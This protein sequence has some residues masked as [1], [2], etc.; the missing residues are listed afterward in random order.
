MKI[1]LIYLSLLGILFLPYACNQIPESKTNQVT[2]ATANQ[3]EKISNFFDKDNT[4]KNP[5][6]IV[7]LID[8]S[9]SMSGARVE[10]VNVDDLKPI[11]EILKSHGGEIA[12]GQICEDSNKPLKRLQIPDIKALKSTDLNNTPKPQRD[13]TGSPF[14]KVKKEQQYQQQLENYQELIDQNTEKIEQHQQDLDKRLKNAEAEITKFQADIQPLLNEPTNCGATDVWGG[15]KRSE[16][17]LQEDSKIW[18]NS[19]QKFA[20]LISDGFHNTGVKPIT[21]KGDSQYILVN[22]LSETVPELNGL[23]VKYFGSPSAAFKDIYA[24]N[25]QE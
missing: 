11:F 21:V 25:Q 23:K 15:I 14:E 10:S 5:L 20:V 13:N 7:I 24:Q 1:N 6:R 17:F 4:V 12:I 3:E 16:V 8:K 18:H 19:P 2:L 22:G 9:S